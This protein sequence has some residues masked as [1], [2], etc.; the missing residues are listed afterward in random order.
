MDAVASCVL[1]SV[2][3]SAG[4]AQDVGRASTRRGDRDEA[5]ADAQRETPPLRHVAVGF[6]RPLELA[7]DFL[8]PSQGTVF[9][10]DAEFVAAEARER[11]AAAQQTVKQAADPAEQLIA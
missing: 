3:G 1:G 5:D 8:R 10:Q 4:G 11:V 2:A 6:D 7:C 9:Q